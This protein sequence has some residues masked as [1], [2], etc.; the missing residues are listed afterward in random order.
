MRSPI[1]R[2]RPRTGNVADAGGAV[3]GAG[4]WAAGDDVG[5][6]VGCTLGNSDGDACGRDGDG[7]AGGIGLG[8]DEHP[9]T[10][11]PTTIAVRSKGREGVIYGSMIVVR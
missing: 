11:A 1:D 4:V 5:A 6:A 10:S 9:I 8:A 2:A 7:V 3:R